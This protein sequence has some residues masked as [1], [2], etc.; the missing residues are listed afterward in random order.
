MGFE[1]VVVESFMEGEFVYINYL[2]KYEFD[3]RSLMFQE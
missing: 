1:R 2:L 3:L